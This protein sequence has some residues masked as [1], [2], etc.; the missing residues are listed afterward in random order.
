MCI[1]DSA[2]LSDDQTQ[3]VAET[4][5]RKLDAAGKEIEDLVADG[6]RAMIDYSR[7]DAM[8]TLQGLHYNIADMPMQLFLSVPQSKYHLVSLVS[9]H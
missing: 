7:E 4:V 3:A 2:I 8:K 1:R 9:D 5:L 6:L